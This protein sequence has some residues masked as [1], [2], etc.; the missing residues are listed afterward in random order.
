MKKKILKPQKSEIILFSFFILFLFVV[1]LFFINLNNKCRG[2]K[3]FNYDQIKKEKV[4]AVLQ[5][6]CGEIVIE[7]FDSLSP[8]N[9]DRFLKFIRT[10]VY[11]DS[12]F[13]RV[14]K[15]KFVEFG[16]LIYGKKNNLDYLKIGTGGSKEKNLKSELNKDYN[17]IKGSVGMVRR[18]KFDTENSQIFILIDDIP[19]FKF[20]YTP[21]GIVISDINVL[22]KIKHQDS[23]SYVLRPDFILDT[24]AIN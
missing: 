16:D 11:I 8:K 7:I 1:S 14:K 10:K 12:Y 15:N 23:S 17:F 2:I 13:Y 22:K 19:S 4:Y 5:V 20:Q 18:G 21:I 9:T 3:N 6:E 24:R